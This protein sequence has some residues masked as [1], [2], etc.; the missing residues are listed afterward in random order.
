MTYTARDR[1]PSRDS[2]IQALSARHEAL[3]QK[4]E[5][6]FLHPS[7]SDEELYEMKARKLRLKD[8]IEQETERRR[9]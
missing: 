8:E 3:S 5:E 6:Q 7:V 4:I 1:Q 9:A 2:H